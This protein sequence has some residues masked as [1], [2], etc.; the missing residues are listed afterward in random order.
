[1][2]KL[3]QL[4]EREEWRGK[5]TYKDTE[6]ELSDPS[7]VE[8]E[9]NKGMFMPTFSPLSGQAVDRIPMTIHTLHS[10]GPFHIGSLLA[11][12]PMGSRT[13]PFNFKASLRAC[14]H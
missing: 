8:E 2:L 13:L 3:K 7:Q 1:M 12:G 10:L 5:V 6:V 14:V 11:L 4:E 9:I